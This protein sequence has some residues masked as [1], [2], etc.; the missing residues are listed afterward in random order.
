MF[1]TRRT[2]DEQELSEDACNFLHIS[3]ETLYDETGRHL[4]DL[5]DCLLLGDRHL[6]EPPAGD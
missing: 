6:D 5:V 1:A 2:R 3:L 4:E